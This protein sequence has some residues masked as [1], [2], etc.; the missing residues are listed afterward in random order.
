MNGPV[1]ELFAGA[2]RR[3]RRT[4]RRPAPIQEIFYYQGPAHNPALRVSMTL[5]GSP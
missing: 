4:Y 5:R 3:D 1:C 2:M